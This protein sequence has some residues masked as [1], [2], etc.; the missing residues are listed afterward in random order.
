MALQFKI[1]LCN[2]QIT[3]RPP[4]PPS[5]FSRASNA[6]STKRAAMGESRQE[7]LQWLNGLLQ[8]NYTKIEQC[9]SGTLWRHA[10]PKWYAAAHNRPPSL[11]LVASLSS[12][13]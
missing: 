7:L 6:R 2:G 13:Q 9:G 10:D 4:H 12:L 5:G 11:R 1:G 3:P 8:L